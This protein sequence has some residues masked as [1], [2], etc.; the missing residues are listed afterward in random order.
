VVILTTLLTPPLL[1]ASFV[2]GKAKSESISPMPPSDQTQVADFLA[3][4]AEQQGEAEIPAE[5]AP[6]EGELT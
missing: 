5:Q 6:S 3:E 1:R 2:K 4:P